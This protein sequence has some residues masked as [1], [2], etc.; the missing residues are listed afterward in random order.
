MGSVGGDSLK[1]R[2]LM[3]RHKFYAGEISVFDFFEIFKN[4][5]Y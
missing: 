3:T 1:M 2:N 4:S 5:N